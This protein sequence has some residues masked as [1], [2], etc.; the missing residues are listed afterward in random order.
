MEAYVISIPLYEERKL[1]KLEEF[2][3]N[4]SQNSGF[5]MQVTNNTVTFLP[6]FINESDEDFKT[7][8]VPAKMFLNPNDSKSYQNDLSVFVS[9]FNRMSSIA[10]S[11]SK[12]H[13][14]FKVL[15]EDIND[16]EL[17]NGAKKL[18]KVILEGSSCLSLSDT[19]LL[20]LWCSTLQKGCPVKDT[21][22]FLFYYS[23]VLASASGA[24]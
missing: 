20:R 3:K 13:L 23:S 21:L 2:V 10:F 8:S 17:F 24:S 15:I 11:R 19:C 1:P 9:R 18:F 22:S 6:T 14:N 5:F 7:Y 12:E 4:F 16:E